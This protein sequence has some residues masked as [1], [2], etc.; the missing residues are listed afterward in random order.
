MH[1]HM[2]EKLFLS[3]LSGILGLIFFQV[4]LT[5]WG[6]H[7]KKILITINLFYIV[8]SY[9]PYTAVTSK[10]TLGTR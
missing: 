2:Y 9:Y 3:I 4:S 6:I 5:L 7:R 8:I 1:S 10:S